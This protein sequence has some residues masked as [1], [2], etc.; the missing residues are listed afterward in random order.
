MSNRTVAVFPHVEKVGRQT[1]P[2]S[3]SPTRVQMTKSFSV[4][5]FNIIFQIEIILKSQVE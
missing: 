2:E 5:E 3:P 4:L 1:D